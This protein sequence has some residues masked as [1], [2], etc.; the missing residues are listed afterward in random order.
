MG[1]KN[2]S[3]KIGKE[4]GFLKRFDAHGKISVNNVKTKWTLATNPVSAGTR[5]VNIGLFTGKEASALPARIALN[6]KNIRP[7]LQR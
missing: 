3:L 6:G 7:S 4:H 1:T 2:S 5:S